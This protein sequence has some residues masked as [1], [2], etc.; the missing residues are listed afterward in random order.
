MYATYWQGITD[1]L[2]DDNAQHVVASALAS[3]TGLLTASLGIRSSATHNSSSGPSASP[4]SVLL[5]VGLKARLLLLQ[6]QQWCVLLWHRDQGNTRRGRADALTA[7]ATF[8][9]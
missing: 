6:Q 1:A 7:D 5:Q 2:L 4:G 8:V 3:T 9:A